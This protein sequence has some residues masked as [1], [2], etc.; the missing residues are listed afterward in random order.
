MRDLNMTLT[1]WVA[2][3]PNYVITRDGDGI[4][5]CTF[6]MGQTARYRDRSTGEWTDAKTEWFTV[7]VFRDAAVSVARSIKKGQPVIVEGRMRTHEWVDNENNKRVTLQIDANAVGHDLS[8]GI[9]DFT[10]AVVEDSDGAQQAED[11]PPLDKEPPV[12]DDEVAALDEPHVAL[13]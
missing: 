10:R 11:A 12:A 4:P 2:A 9:S 6:R 13:T 8:F 5:M 7:R 3:D 1:G